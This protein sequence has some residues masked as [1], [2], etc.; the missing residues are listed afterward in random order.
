M[1]DFGRRIA[2][3]TP[4]EVQRDPEVIRAYL[5]SGDDDEPRPR[6]RPRGRL[7][8]DRDLRGPRM[9]TFLTLLLNGIS[10]GA[11]YA[12]IALGFAIIF[13]ASEVV[14][15]MHGSLL[16]LGAYTIARLDTSI[17]FLP[18]V[19]VGIAGHG[20]RRPARGAAAHQPAARRAGHQ[21]GDPHHRHRH[22]DPHRAHPPDRLGHPQRRPPVGR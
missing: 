8:P 10:L 18:A 20:R 11:I 4:A 5:G 19:L 12:L 3:G 15:F 6:A 17:G 22:H 21:P 9:N 13:K 7:H 2:D 1:L 16:L 14:S